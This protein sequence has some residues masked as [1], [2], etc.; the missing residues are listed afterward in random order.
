MTYITFSCDVGHTFGS[1]E[2]N[3]MTKIAEIRDAANNAAAPV[4][5]FSRAADRKRKRL[6][7]VTI[8]SDDSRQSSAPCPLFFLSW[9]D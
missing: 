1:Q 4:C 3:N 5:T 7:T 8:F 2:R 9:K 6:E